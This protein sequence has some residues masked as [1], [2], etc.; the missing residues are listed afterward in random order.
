MRVA[1]PAYWLLTE[2]MRVQSLLYSLFYLGLAKRRSCKYIYCQNVLLARLP[3]SKVRS[4][5]KIH[6]VVLVKAFTTTYTH[7]RISCWQLVLAGGISQSFGFQFPSESM[8]R[9]VYTHVSRF[10][11]YTEGNSCGKGSI[12]QLLEN[13]IQLHNRQETATVMSRYL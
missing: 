13:V 6:T 1:L 8:L 10:N 2:F 9:N 5:W 12:T 7:T 11:Q 3:S 4:S